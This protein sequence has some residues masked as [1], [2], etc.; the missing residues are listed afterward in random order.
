MKRFYHSLTFRI[1]GIIVLVEI[2]A[3]TMAGVV[4]VNRFSAE[5]DQRIEEHA[6]LP[7][8]LMNAGLLSFDS[9]ADQATM[10]RLVG[11]ELMAGMVVGVNGNIFYSLQSEYVGQ[12]IDQA[13]GVDVGLFDPKQPQENLVHRDNSLVAVSPIFGADKQTPRFFVY[14][15][16]ETSAAEATK[17]GVRCLFV[18]GSVAT[19]VITSVVLLL[20]FRWA[21]FARIAVLLRVLARAAAGDLSA[22]V[23]GAISQDEIGSL[24]HGANAMIAERKQA[25][26]ALLEYREHLEELVA[27]RTAEL[28]QSEEKARA[29]YKGIP[30]PTYTW[31][32]VGQDLV[33]VDY[34]DA[35]G[36]ITQGKVA[37]LVGMRLTD[38]Y[39]DTPEIREEIE[40]CFAERISIEREMPYRFRSTG[41]SKVL[42]VK[43]A[44]V[45]PDLVLIHTEDITERV[46][47]EQEVQQQAAELRK[48]VNLMAGREVRMAELKDVIRQLRA[49]LEKAGLAPAAN[50]PLFGP[51][52]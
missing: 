20:A 47:A 22:R 19:V 18:L 35:A 3:L 12:T 24:Q 11:E 40:R 2:V 13:P 34:N 27:E 38:M 50:D 32:K 36:A 37:D 39:R 21:I 25:E 29:Q 1:G 31:Q 28:R 15:A 26:Q 5:V 44:F 23:E 10:R 14:V 17:A 45:P 7:G 33:L 6:L 8:V 30:V 16:L 41:E 9:V 51:G 42:A 4:Y 43:Y 46:H 52:A 48:M 49:Q